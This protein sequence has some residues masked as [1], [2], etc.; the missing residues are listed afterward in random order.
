MFLVSKIRDLWKREDIRARNKYIFRKVDDLEDFRKA[1]NKLSEEEEFT[2]CVSSGHQAFY[3]LPTG[4][5]LDNRMK[6]ISFQKRL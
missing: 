2:S 3:R 5:H 1:D 6:K 4:C